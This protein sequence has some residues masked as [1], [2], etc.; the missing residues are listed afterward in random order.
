M[1]VIHL[2]MHIFT[3]FEYSII[4]SS[5]CPYK[6]SVLLGHVTS[7]V[8]LDIYTYLDNDNN[9]TKNKLETYL[10]DKQWQIT[11]KMFP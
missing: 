9:V 11:I 2:F 7:S 5:N 6:C 4:N 8:T 3:I 10:N 1:S